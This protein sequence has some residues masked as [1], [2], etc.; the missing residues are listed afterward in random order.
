MGRNAMNGLDVCLD[1]CLDVRGLV[2]HGSPAFK[3]LTLPIKEIG[4]SL[5][6]PVGFRRR[7]K[8]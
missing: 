6:G 4:V 5:W 7:H 8:L 1:V 3:P 2:G